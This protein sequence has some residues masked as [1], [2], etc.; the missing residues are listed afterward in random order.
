MLLG[1]GVSVLD[2][3]PA[4]GIRISEGEMDA[5]PLWRRERANRQEIGHGERKR[6][7]WPQQGPPRIP[8]RR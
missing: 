5:E 1:G 3:E 8:R 2:D 6:L 4:V 7:T